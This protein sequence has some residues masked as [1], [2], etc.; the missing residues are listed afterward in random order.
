MNLKEGQIVRIKA[1]E[2]LPTRR[3]G[4]LASVRRIHPKHTEFV[5][6]LCHSDAEFVWLHE[7]QIGEV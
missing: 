2:E 6:V 1:T 3:D 7:S 4:L 5:L